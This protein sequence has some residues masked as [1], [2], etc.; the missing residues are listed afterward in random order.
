MFRC[1]YEDSTFGTSGI[2]ATG[3]GLTYYSNWIAKQYQQRPSP[4]FLPPWEEPQILTLGLL[5]LLAPIGM[6]L[7]VVANTAK[8]V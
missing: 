4:T 8:I 2:K 5:F 3:S 7:G 6:I 1:G